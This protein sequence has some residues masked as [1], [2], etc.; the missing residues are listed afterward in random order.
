MFI[1]SFIFSITKIG[2][3]MKMIMLFYTLHGPIC[4]TFRKNTLYPEYDTFETV[5]P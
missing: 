1:N 4:R 2:A 3:V 5:M